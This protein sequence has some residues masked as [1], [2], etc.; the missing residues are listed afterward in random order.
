MKKGW[1]KLIA[2]VAALVVVITS[3]TVQNISAVEPDTVI[4][5]ITVT[6]GQTEARSMLDMINEFRTGDDAWAWDEEGQRVEYHNLQAL[7]YDPA[8]ERVAMQRAAE[9]IFSWS[10]TRPNGESCFTAYPSGYMARGE[11]IARW[12]YSAEEA[13]VSWRE[14]NEDYSGQGHRRN[15]LSEEFTAVGIAHVVYNGQHYWVQEFG[16]PASGETVSAPVDGEQAVSIEFLNEEQKITGI[17]LG[18]ENIYGS[19]N[20]AEILNALAASMTGVTI[21]TDKDREYSI[22]AQVQYDPEANAF[23][24]AAGSYTLPVT[25]TDPDSLM[26]SEIPLQKV[27]SNY[28]ADQSRTNSY[29]VHED[30]ELEIGTSPIYTDT[31][32]L[33][34]TWYKL[35]D[36]RLAQVPDAS[37]KSCNIEAVST[38][39]AGKYVAVYTTR[40][41]MCLSKDKTVTVTPHQAVEGEG[42]TPTCTEDGY[43]GG[44]VCS[45]C[46]K[47]L[48]EGGTLIPALGHAWDEGT[49]TKEA[50]C[51]EAGERTYTCSRCE[52]TKKETISATGHT[53]VTDPAVE[54]TCTEPGRTEGKHCSVCGMIL[55][56]SQKI[57]ELG[58]DWDD[59]TVTKEA[60]CTED[61]ERTYVCSRCEE[62]KKDSI[63]ATGHTEVIDQAAAATCTKPGYTQGSHCSVCNKVLS[64][65]TE[66]PALGHDWDDGTVTKEATCTEG[67]ERTY[68]CGRC[69]E[70][71]TEKIPAKGHTEVTDPAVE[72]TCTEPG[73]TEGKR[74][75]VCGTILVES[76]EISELGHDWDEGSVTKEATCTEDGEISYNCSRCEE[77]KKE[78]ISATGHT[79]V[80]DP[81]VEATCTEPGRTEGKHCSVCGTILVKSEEIPASGHS[82]VDAAA[83]EPTCTEPGYTKGTYCTVCK[84]YTSGHEVIPATGHTEVIDPAVEPTI[85]QEG[86]TEGSH[87]S[88]CGTLLKEQTIIPKLEKPDNESG[89]EKSD[90]ADTGAVRTGDMTNAMPLV[91]LVT[92]SFFAAAAVIN[93]RRS[94]CDRKN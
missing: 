25:V 14:D 19:S 32:I 45:V 35:V 59:G 13:F 58:H 6:Y 26:Q 82:N 4:D 63:P 10:H 71:K 30:K 69:E 65:P 62:T 61:G 93:R 80:T 3:G 79:E 85:T 15:M 49:T 74:C 91:G 37:G 24:V 67:G 43:S 2:A 81:A 57:S 66:I 48:E 28:D 22:E 84:I 56:E 8:L 40:S 27:N 94:G 5:E 50:T 92:V 1:K 31:S 20:S 55:V 54:A 42:K 75:S 16:S 68:V 33:S 7:T 72:A 76:Q 44:S 73:R 64:K 29:T 11:N 86:K 77:T 53:E 87:C 9:I 78:T 21:R 17:Y 51:T 83:T 39:D 46:N 12:Q 47:V 88:V 41:G 52:E 89:K 90:N 70:T 60:T 18:Q 38:E 36:G 23:K 34:W